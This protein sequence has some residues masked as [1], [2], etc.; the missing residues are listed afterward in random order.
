[1]RQL[2]VYL[3]VCLQVAQTQSQT[4]NKSPVA[5]GADGRLHTII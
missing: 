5:V 4:G 2:Y 1:M 3:I